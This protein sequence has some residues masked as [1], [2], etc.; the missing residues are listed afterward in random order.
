MDV[1]EA[2]KLIE[3]GFTPE[4][5]RAEIQKGEESVPSGGTE[6]DAEGK[7]NVTQ[8]DHQAEIG[9]QVTE[10]SK[11]VSDLKDT[12]RM[13]QEANIKNASSGSSNAVSPVDENIKSFLSQL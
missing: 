9:A 11:T 7:Q 10:L 13:L 1:S 12:I 5:I 3:A 6:N 8:N 4:Q 2:L